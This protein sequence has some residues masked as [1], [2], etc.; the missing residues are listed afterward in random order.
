M[1]EM[2]EKCFV[3]IFEKMPKTLIDAYFENENEEAALGEDAEP[4]A[5]FYRLIPMLQRYV[6]L[7]QRRIPGKA[8]KK[9]ARFQGG[10]SPR[11]PTY[12]RLT[13]TF[14]FRSN[15]KPGFSSSIVS[16]FMKISHV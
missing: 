5:K 6:V 10:V 14:A 9:D 8:Y 15:K 3:L 4:R 2:R 12:D 13:C 1:P 11:L 7:R 16:K